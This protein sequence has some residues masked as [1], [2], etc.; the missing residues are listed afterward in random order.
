[1]INDTWIRLGVFI[2]VLVIMMLW[3]YLRP[4][5][6]SPVST[7]KRWFSN[8]FLVLLG[9]LVARLMVPT[10]L[11]AMA[12]YA[13]NDQIGLWNQISVSLWVS[14]PVSVLLFDCLIYWQHRLFHR[15]PMFWRI[16]RV[17][18][19]DPHLDAS[20]GLRFHPIEIA[21]SLIVKIA[22]VL[23]L[24]APVLAILIFEV[25]L[26]ATSIFNHSNIKLPTKLDKLLKIFIVTQA[27]HRI[28]HSQVVHETDSN[29]GFNLSIWDR[30]FGSYIEDAANGDEGIK[31]GLKEY[32][33]PQTN[34]NLKALLLMPFR[35]KPNQ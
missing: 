10:G 16:H 9:S 13:Q 6:L 8:F 12:I 2:S 23:L 24:G 21:L 32:A 17:H 20:T 18:H 31:L 33:S 15:V 7:G 4:N 19:A 3:E 35:Q 1:M 34:T 5:R 22:A 27:M 14:V 11:A 30:L 28:H 25:L 26:N 29:F